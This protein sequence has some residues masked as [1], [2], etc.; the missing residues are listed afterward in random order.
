MPDT[1]L[2]VVLKLRDAAS[3]GVKEFGKTST[4]TFTTAKRAAEDF[5]K[6]ASAGIAN[7]G[8]EIEL[9]KRQ[10]AQLNALFGGQVR[11]FDNRSGGGAAGAAAAAAAATAATAA[12]V[13]VERAHSKSA[14]GGRTASHAIQGIALGLVTMGGSSESTGRKVAHLAGSTALAFAHG[15]PVAGALVFATTLFGILG[16]EAA[17][18]EE[19]EKKAREETLEGIRKKT[20]EVKNLRE[21]VEK[22]HDAERA[23][24]TGGNVEEAVGTGEFTRKREDAEGELRTAADAESKVRRQIEDVRKK[25]RKQAEGTGVGWGRGRGGFGGPRFKS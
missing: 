13:A 21:E 8:K 7:V 16:E 20:E 12:G 11:G 5:S 18:A 24:R 10:Q 6:T 25:A 17:K 4:D 14:L 23:G 9:T 15:G 3:A 22:L 1:E 19:K 2:Q